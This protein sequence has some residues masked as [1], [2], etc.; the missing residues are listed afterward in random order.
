SRGNRISV[1]SDNGIEPLVVF[2]GGL[3]AGVIVNPINAE[4]RE[5]HV[6]QILH[7]V[8][9]KL[10]FWSTELPADPRGLWTGGAPWIPFGGWDA[11]RPSD[12]DLFAKLKEASDA[13]VSVRPARAD[14]S[15]I[16]YTS[17]TTDTPKGAIWTHETYYAMTE[18]PT[19]RLEITAA[20]TILDY[21]HF[22][23]SS[24]QILS[25]G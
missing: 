19:D 4:I 25:I 17:G 15:L 16:N 7:D 18:S 24:P 22:S 8:K 14:W 3:R 11:P 9:P 10:V 21:R 5:K 12:E 13:P 2:W 6:S 20:D 1:L 23:W